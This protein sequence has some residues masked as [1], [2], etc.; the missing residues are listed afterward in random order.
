MKANTTWAK[1]CAVAG[2]L[3]LG[4]A[5]SDGT[6][7]SPLGGEDAGDDPFHNAG[8]GR[9][10][11]GGPSPS[12]FDASTTGEPPT[13]GN[14]PFGADAVPP[15]ILLVIDRSGSMADTPDGFG[16]DKWS[17]MKA[18]VDTALASVQDDVALGL[19]L[20]PTGGDACGVEAASALSVP[21]MPGRQALPDITSA[22]DGATPGGA[23]PTAAA[24]TSALDYFT[25][26]PGR[27]LEGDRFVLLATDGGP[28]CNADATCDADRCTVNLDGACPAAV[29]NCCDSSMAGADAEVG[30]LDA[31]ETLLA[32]DA[33]AAAD[34]ETFVIGIPG[35]EV[36]QSSLD[37]FAEAGGRPNPDAPPSYFAATATG[38][39]VGGLTGILERITAAVIRTCSLQ[40]AS[41]PPDRNRLN[42]EVDGETVPQFGA[43]GWEL[44]D[45]TDPPT[46]VLKGATCD[47]IE[48][49]G[50]DSV[51]VVFG[52]PTVVE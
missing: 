18:A 42:V 27:D 32:I 26:G 16:S 5:C 25:D 50:V 33:L 17:A 45:D 10:D 3:L 4:S 24:L 38:G 49:E 30:C 23:T 48:Q 40:L 11:G 47:R 37:A 8:N 52:C 31:G 44:T 7:D 35:S 15:N 1:A 2:A 14:E 39:G 19:E 12:D 22:L 46:L 20:Y 43:D 13:C 41:E 36:Y 6:D 28:N 29:D 34:I 21:V 51:N 9:A